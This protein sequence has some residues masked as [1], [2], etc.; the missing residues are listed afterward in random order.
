V[1]SLPSV[2]LCPCFRGGSPIKTGVGIGRNF[3]DQSPKAENSLKPPAGGGEG[4]A[5]AGTTNDMDVEDLE[6]REDE[7]RLRDRI[8]AEERVKRIGESG[9]FPLSPTTLGLQAKLLKIICLSQV[10]C[11]RA[12]HHQATRLTRA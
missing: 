12:S 4:D 3:F 1:S 7:L 11:L 9:P 10:I 6:L 2:H 8:E 5:G